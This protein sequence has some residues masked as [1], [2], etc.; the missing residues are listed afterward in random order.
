[1]THPVIKH[2]RHQ[3]LLALRC[4]NVVHLEILVEASV[5]SCEHGPDSLL[6]EGVEVQA[7]HNCNVYAQRPMKPATGVAHADAKAR[8]DPVR[9][10]GVA[11]DAGPVSWYLKDVHDY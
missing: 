2:A 5:A 7:A 10:G 11:V 8:R 9:T 4:R 6:V 1:M 3:V